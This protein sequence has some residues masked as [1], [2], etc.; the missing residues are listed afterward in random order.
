MTNPLGGDNKN[1]LHRNCFLLGS[2][3]KSFFF[4]LSLLMST[5]CVTFKA[6]IITLHLGPK[7][8]KQTQLLGIEPSVIK[9]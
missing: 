5:T 7:E 6:I 8:I 2:E 9:A 4:F 3:N 1:E